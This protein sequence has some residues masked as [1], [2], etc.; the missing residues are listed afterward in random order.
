M[1]NLELTRDL[2]RML[3]IVADYGQIA[4]DTLLRTGRRKS[5]K[6]RADLSQ[7]LKADYV[8]RVGVDIEISRAGLIALDA[9][10]RKIAN[11]V[12]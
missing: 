12:S 7:L 9:S 1:T 8:R 4:E 5:D 2:R 11:A 10:P 3:L 6:K